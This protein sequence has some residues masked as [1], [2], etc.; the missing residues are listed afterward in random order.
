MRYLIGSVSVLDQTSVVPTV[1]AL[2]FRYSQ[3]TVDLYR[4]LR[5]TLDQLTP[6]L[7]RRRRFWFPDALTGQSDVLLPGHHEDH[8][9][10]VYGCSNWKPNMQR[11][12]FHVIVFDYST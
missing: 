3:R 10:R 1:V 4:Y 2:E 12:V 5:R 8:S 9:E 6:L 7:P 11:S